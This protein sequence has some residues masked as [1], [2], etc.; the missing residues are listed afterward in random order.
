LEACLI[1]PRR[2]SK[3]PIIC[4]IT[5]SGPGLAVRFMESLTPTP[6]LLSIT[7]NMYYIFSLSARRVNL[8]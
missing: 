5:E 1:Q 6:P 8:S 7:I 2:L 4:R 3:T